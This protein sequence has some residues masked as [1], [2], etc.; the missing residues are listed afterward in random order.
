MGKKD[1]S[2]PQSLSTLAGGVKSKWSDPVKDEVLSLYLR[3]YTH[4]WKTLL[5]SIQLK[6]D[7]SI[8]SKKGAGLSFDIYALRSLVSSDSPLVNLTKKVVKETTLAQPENSIVNVPNVPNVPNVN[9]RMLNNV[10]KI[11]N[12][13]AFREKKMLTEGVDRHFSALRE[14]VVGSSTST[15]KGEGNDTTNGNQLGALIG[16]LKD[17]Y[18]QLV[19]SDNAIKDGDISPPLSESGKKLTAEST[20]WPQPFRNIIEPLLIGAHKRINH[21]IVSNSNKTIKLNLGDVCK[22]TLEGRYPFAN[23]QQEVSM[24]DFERFFSAGGLVDE[25]FKKNLADKVVIVG[26]PS[27]RGY[28]LL[29]MKMINIF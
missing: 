25:Y 21:K 14:F 29:Q 6:S 7:R 15:Q 23:S 8:Q 28:C 16:M 24:N 10:A 19:I 13:L 27:T 17:Q 1:D 11:N 2:L 4:Q 20:T 5:D 22:N 18:T 9:N 26:N 12:V 3:E